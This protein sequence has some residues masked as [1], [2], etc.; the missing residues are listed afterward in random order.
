MLKPGGAF[1]AKVF[2][3]KDTDLLY[4][5][6]K[7]FFPDI[8]ICKPRS[9]RN[10]SIEAFVVCRTFTPV[11]G[12]VPSILSPEPGE[13]QCAEQLSDV[14]RIIVPFL[15]AGDLSGFDADMSYPLA[16]DAEVLAPVMPPKS[17]P[18]MKALEIQRGRLDVASG[19]TSNLA[20]LDIDGDAE[21][22]TDIGS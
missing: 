11:E 12:Y 5:Q 17:P 20:K 7:I 3:Q 13:N 8:V 15:S 6:L 1:V 19:T 9:S 22:N 18:Y 16:P 2:R 4:S 10:S 14:N 21:S